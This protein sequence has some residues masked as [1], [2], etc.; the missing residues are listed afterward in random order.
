MEAQSNHSLLF[1]ARSN[2][3]LPSEPS[4]VTYRS[5]LA[6]SFCSPLLFKP[7]FLDQLASIIKFLARYF[8]LIQYL[9]TFVPLSQFDTSSCIFK[10][11]SPASLLTYRNSTNINS[12]S[13]SVTC[14][15]LNCRHSP[16]RTDRRNSPLSYC[17]VYYVQTSSAPATLAPTSSCSDATKPLHHFATRES[18]TA[19]ADNSII[20]RSISFLHGYGV[21]VSSASPTARFRNVVPRLARLPL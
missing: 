2:V 19:C 10:S 12:I 21:I 11:R 7:Y 14:I 20:Q 6:D 17:A 8:F 13:K 16:G 3:T 4:L 9:S 15:H 18:S 5:A 1:C